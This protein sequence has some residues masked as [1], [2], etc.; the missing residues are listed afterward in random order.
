MARSKFAFSAVLLLALDLASP[1]LAQS[2]TI[3]DL[4]TLGGTWS[5]AYG[6]NDLGRVVGVSQT[7]PGNARAFIWQNGAMTPIDTLGGKWSWGLGINNSGQIVGDSAT[8]SGEGHAFLWQSGMAAPRDLGSLG[9]TKSYASDINDAGQVVG[10]Y[11]LGPP[12]GFTPGG[13]SPGQQRAF[14]WQGNTMIDLNTTVDPGSGWTLHW[15]AGINNSGEEP[16]ITVER[17][18]EKSVKVSVQAFCYEAIGRG[19]RPLP[20][21]ACTRTAMRGIERE[22]AR[23]DVGK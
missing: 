9:G 4:G 18:S 7:T 22:V 23:T 5:E 11:M 3:T 14:L 10:N 6:I 21:D 2:Y 16:F 15:A 17:R 20:P 8:T 12:A 13:Y 1:P 19:K